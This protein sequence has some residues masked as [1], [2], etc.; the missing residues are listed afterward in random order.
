MWQSQQ[1]PYTQWQWS[2]TSDQH[3]ARLKHSRPFRWYSICL[4]NM[5]SIWILFTTKYEL[6]KLFHLILYN[7]TVITAYVCIKYIPV[8]RS[9]GLISIVNQNTEKLWLKSHSKWTLMK[10]WW[11][12]RLIG[13]TSH[14]AFSISNLWCIDLGKTYHSILPYIHESFIIRTFYFPNGHSQAIG[15]TLCNLLISWIGV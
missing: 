13:L 8:A 1:T 3:N 14:H 7:F 4:V 5:Q 9:N 12:S 10:I 6:W 15:C 2:L 11:L